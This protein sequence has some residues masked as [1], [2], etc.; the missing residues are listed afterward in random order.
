MPDTP[1]PDTI[2]Y[3][4]VKASDYRTV[5]ATGA[6]GG[7]TPQGLVAADLF[8]EAAQVPDSITH[9]FT[10]EGV[11]GEE[12]GRD[13]GQSAPCL[14]RT[15]Q[16]RVMMTPDTARKVGEWLIEK[17]KEFDRLQQQSKGSS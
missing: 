6:W 5:L 1:I 8:A 10:P 9:A 3:R 7:L 2:N 16:V 11:P 14:E 12:I 15:L 17:A 13:W 4:F